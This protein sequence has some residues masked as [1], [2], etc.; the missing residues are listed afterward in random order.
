MI[1]KIPCD[2]M[3]RIDTGPLQIGTDYPG[4]FIR[5]DEAL[6]IADM[7]VQLRQQSRDPLLIKN[8]LIDE[9]VKTL[10]SCC[11]RSAA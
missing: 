2:L 10:R 5:G 11:V 1:A 3:V 7:L 6:G 4:V 9:L 8:S